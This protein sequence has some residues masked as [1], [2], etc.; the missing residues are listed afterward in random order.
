MT[1]IFQRIDEIDSEK[2]AMVA[3]RLEDRAQMPQFTAMRER[4]LDRIG[5]PMDGNIL[6]IGCGSGAVC[7]AIAMRPGFSGKITGSDLSASLIETAN[8]IT[9]EAGIDGIR[10]YQA[11]GQ[12]SVEA[13]G[14]YDLVLAHTVISHVTDPT[15]LL[16][17]AGR[18]TT[19]GGRIIIH[20]GDYASVVFESGNAELDAKMPLLLLRAVVANPFVMRQMPRLLGDLDVEVTHALG[21]VV[22]ETAAAEYFPNMVENYAPLIADNGWAA[23][24][25]VESWIS[26]VLEAVS[27]GTFFGSCNFVTY[28]ATKP[29]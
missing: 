24:D 19:P 27:K 2:Q 7:R 13:E 3:K 12:A 28:S 26:G 10:Y 17:E 22:V 15:A 8:R 9:A 16:A 25:E 5:L 20:D 29:G 23:P 14:S 1:D 11:D 6:E 18:L 4:Y 21:D